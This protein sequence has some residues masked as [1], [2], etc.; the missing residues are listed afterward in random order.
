MVSHNDIPR[1]SHNLPYTVV[2]PCTLSKERLRRTTTVYWRLVHRTAPLV[3]HH[4]S[5]IM[6]LY[7]AWVSQ[8][9]V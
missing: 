3:F 7:F 6:Y 4:I 2:G 5:C 1:T 8:M 9:T